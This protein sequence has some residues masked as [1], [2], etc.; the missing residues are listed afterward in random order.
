MKMTLKA[1]RH[2]KGLTQEQLAEAVGVTSRTIGSWEKGR[3]M[4]NQDKIRKICIAC[5]IEFS[6]IDWRI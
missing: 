4:P 5:E 1:A 2:N 3:A 6:D